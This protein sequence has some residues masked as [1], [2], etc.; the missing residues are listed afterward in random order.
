MDVPAV[1]QEIRGF[2]GCAQLDAASNLKYIM[3]H[4]HCN[5][6][7]EKDVGFM[8]A[9]QGMIGCGNFGIPLVDTTS[10]RVEVIYYNVADMEVR[11]V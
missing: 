5:K 4:T 9:G 1:Y 6:V 8:V 10:G 7:T 2:D 11:D 3:G